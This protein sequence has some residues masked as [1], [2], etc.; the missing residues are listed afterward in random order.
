MIKLKDFVRKLSERNDI[1]LTCSKDICY[2]FIDTLNYLLDNSEEDVYLYG[3]GTFKHETRKA[4]VLRHP[5]TGELMTM[6]ERNVITFK[7]TEHILS[8]DEAYRQCED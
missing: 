2:A 3:L 7:R 8:P 4:K 5:K 1:T 6:P